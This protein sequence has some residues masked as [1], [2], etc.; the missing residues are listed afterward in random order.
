MVYILIQ[1]ESFHNFN[2]QIVTP[3]K[4]NSSPKSI[5]STHVQAGWATPE[6]R[7]VP[8]CAST[9][10]WAD[11]SMWRP[12]FLV[13]PWLGTSLGLGNER[14]VY[15][16]LS[17]GNNLSLLHGFSPVSAKGFTE[18]RKPQGTL[19]S[20]H[21]GKRGWKLFSPHLSIFPLYGFVAGEGKSAS[22][23][24]NNNR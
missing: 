16:S 13:L 18:A 3:G 6:P 12:G 20:S 8:L 1:A 9:Q 17:G 5:C 21:L 2:H 22:L 10:V 19:A 14:E 15:F 11:L 23:Q 7:A 24:V 4:D